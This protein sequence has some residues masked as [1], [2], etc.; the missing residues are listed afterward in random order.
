M[1]KKTSVLLG[2]FLACAPAAH[3]I[4]NNASLMIGVK[5]L[6]EKDWEPNEN[7]GVLGVQYDI[8]K[9][10]WPLSIVGDVIASGSSHDEFLH[11]NEGSTIELALGVR[12]YWENLGPW[13]PF[14][15]GGPAFLSAQIEDTNLLSGIKV[16]DHDSTAGI[17]VGGGILRQFST[18][19]HMGLNVR[20]SYG[21]VVLFNDSKN[22]GGVLFN[23]LAGFRFN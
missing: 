17:W 6:S 13:R 19:F 7:Q 16:E 11:D 15:G 4:V 8:R 1:I 3:A 14:I 9:E 10:N 23:V 21:K 2:F 20:A 22:A 18:N 5:G 12:K